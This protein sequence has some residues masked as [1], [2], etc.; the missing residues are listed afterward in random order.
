MNH[1]FLTFLDL[2]DPSWESATLPIRDF[3]LNRSLFPNDLLYDN[4]VRTFLPGVVKH[5]LFN[6]DCHH[7]NSNEYPMGHIHYKACCH[8]LFKER[9]KENLYKPRNKN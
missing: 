9:Y 8:K 6:H 5:V 2:P 3:Y 7:C 1:N 4:F